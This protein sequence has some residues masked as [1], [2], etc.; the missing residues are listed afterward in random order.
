MATN[1]LDMRA[2]YI[3]IFVVVFTLS[4][5]IVTIFLSGDDEDT[6]HVNQRLDMSISAGDNEL[7]VEYLYDE[8]M[9]WGDHKVMVCLTSEIGTGSVNMIK[10]SAE[11]DLT[12]EYGDM[13]FFR[14]P[15]GNWDPLEGMEYTVR[16][17]RIDTNKVVWEDEFRAS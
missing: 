8:E 14:D 2:V 10:L 1:R 11:G 16:I 12:T 9:D 3:A 7:V 13:I 17:V 6:G 15:D 4:V 5:V